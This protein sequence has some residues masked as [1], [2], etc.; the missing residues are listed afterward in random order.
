M[1][2][3]DFLT[4]L[5]RLT[6]FVIGLVTL[7]SYLRHRDRTRFDIMLVFAVF[8]IAVTFQELAALNNNDPTLNLLNG[9]AA[10]AQPYLQL[11]VVDHFRRVPFRIKVIGFGGM[12]L[13][14][15]L[16]PLI[17]PSLPF[18]QG[19]SIG[20]TLT[21]TLLIV[22]W[23]ALVEGYATIAFIRG[24]ITTA[25][26][27]RW[28]LGLAS[29]G[30]AFIVLLAPEL[31][32]YTAAVTQFLSLASG[33]SYYL[34]FAPP[35]FLRH[36]WQSAELYH[37]LRDVNQIAPE[38]RG[39]EILDRLCDAANRAVG[40]LASVVTQWREREQQLSI[41]SARTTRRALPPMGAFE[42]SDG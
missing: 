3:N 20:A 37:F 13:S 27:T 30:S 16:L 17:S 8:A 11:R 24:A 28:R 12:V 31:A 36:W 32:L 1:N 29:L 34:G 23:F 5:T 19:L 39:R 18:R 14:W 42:L 9:L 2:L 15:L 25:G 7:L 22:V 21:A 6:F 35:R 38:K 33:V 4:N 41:V 40:A 10:L 26:V